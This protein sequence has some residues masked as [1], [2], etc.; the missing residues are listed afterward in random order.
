MV[1]ESNLLDLPKA[2]AT[3]FKPGVYAHVASDFKFHCP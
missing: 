3:Q 2:T 1:N